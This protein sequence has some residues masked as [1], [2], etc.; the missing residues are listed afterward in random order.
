MVRLQ[1][2]HVHRVLAEEAPTFTRETRASKAFCAARLRGL[3]VLVLPVYAG[4]ELL[5]FTV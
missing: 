3:P 1:V 5:L 4:E 2:A